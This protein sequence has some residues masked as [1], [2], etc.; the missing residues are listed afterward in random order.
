MVVIAQS[1]DFKKLLL[2]ISLKIRFRLQFR[3]TDVNSIANLV[4]MM[5]YNIILRIHPLYVPV[6]C[7]DVLFE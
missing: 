5:R 4:H 6:D 7:L 2:F 1:R 3:H